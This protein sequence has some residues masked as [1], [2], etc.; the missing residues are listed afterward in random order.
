MKLKKAKYTYDNYLLL[1]MTFSSHNDITLEM[2][3]LMY[4]GILI[5]LNIG[6]LFFILHKNSLSISHILYQ[7]LKK[8][9]LQ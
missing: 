1:N 9:K 7:K 6:V 5:V 4:E 8:L 3:F 2:H